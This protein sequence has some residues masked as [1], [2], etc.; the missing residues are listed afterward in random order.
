MGEL[1]RR[2]AGRADGEL[3]RLTDA[4]D[5]GDAEEIASISHR[6]AG[7]A[8]VFGFHQLGD[9][10]KEVEDALDHGAPRAELERSCKIL[11]T[12]LGSLDA[13]SPA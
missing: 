9:A 6:L 8:G 7:N 11:V 13:R 4:I 10:A 3:R 2:F 1:R 12:Q 5:R